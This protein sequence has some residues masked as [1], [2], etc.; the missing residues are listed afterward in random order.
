MKYQVTGA[1]YRRCVDDGACQP[2]EDLPHNR[3]WASADKPVVGVSYTDAE[4]YAAWLSKKT[5]SVWHLPTDEQ[6][7]FAAGTRF[8]DDAVGIEGDE[9]KNPALR[10]LRDYEQQSARKQDR[11]QT[12]RPLGAF[13]ENEYGLADIGGNVWEWTQTCHRRVNIDAY[14]KVASETTVCGVYVVNGKH[15]AAMSSFIRNPKTGGCSVGVPPD[16]LGFRLVRDG[17][18]Y[19]PVLMRLKDFTS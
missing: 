14:G 13:G 10:W 16:N 12:V 1:E 9:S 2:P 15:R 5:G 18:W 11:N 3:N 17:R 6:W 4:D 8:A 19:A 7:A